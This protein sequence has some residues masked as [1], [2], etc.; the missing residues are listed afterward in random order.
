MRARR[1][2]KESWSSVKEGDMSRISCACAARDESG[3]WLMVCDLVRLEDGGGFRPSVPEAA[4]CLLSAVRIGL[5][6]RGGESSLVGIV[7]IKT[8]L[9]V[10]QGEVQRKKLI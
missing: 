7:Q 5:R 9:E 10:S 2:S 6:S 8:P 3:S 1:L 4:S